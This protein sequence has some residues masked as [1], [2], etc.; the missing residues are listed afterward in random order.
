MGRS[1]F[2]SPVYGCGIGTHSLVSTANGQGIVI[3]R[4]FYDFTDSVTYVRGKHSLHF[5]G[6]INRSQVNLSS[7]HFLAGLIYPSFADFLL[8]NSLESVDVP[9]VFS[10]EWRVWDGN[11][12]AQDDFKITQRLT[13]N[14]GFRYE[15][16]GQL[17][18]YLGRAS[19]FNPGA[20]NPD[21]PAAGTL[22]GYVVSSNF[23]GGAIPSGVVRA[24][25]NTAINN[26]GQNG[27]EPRVGFA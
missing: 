13:L 19:T 20:A 16:Q 12:F 15:W 1:G 22:E 7:F 21:P 6:G 11:L 4:N 27:Y 5:G 24:S 9:G 8:G 2:G 25:T 14:L 26:E 3:A 17:G 10:R 23:S 18:E